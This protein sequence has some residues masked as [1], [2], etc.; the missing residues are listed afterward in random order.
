MTLAEALQARL[1]EGLPAD[2][3]KTALPLPDHGWT[4]E[5]D[6]DRVESLG[7]RLNGL[8]VVR[9]EP[10]ADDDAAVEAAARRAASRVTGLMEPLRFIEIDRLRHVALVRSDAPPTKGNDVHFYEVRFEGMNRIAV[11]RQQAAKSSPAAKRAV[12]FTLTHEAI[13]KLVDDLT[14][15]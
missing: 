9:A 2:A 14:R 11:T 15:E 8:A 1:A 3:G 4:V 13:A 10:R 5:V 7:C 6:A 12:P